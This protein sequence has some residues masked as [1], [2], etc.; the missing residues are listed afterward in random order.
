MRVLKF[1]GSS[2]ADGDAIRSVAS[3]VAAQSGA[4][5]VV[6]SALAGVT[7]ALV[8]LANA[9][10]SGAD[11]R[12]DLDA[13]E[14]RH[15]AIART[16]SDPQRRRIA[17][18]S[19]TGFAES[20]GRT[21]RAIKAEARI[22]PWLLDKL[23]AV[24]ELWSSR[25]VDGLLQEAGVDSHWTDA[26]GV[27]KTD[28]RHQAASPDLDATVQCLDRLVR[29]WLARQRVVV[30][31][32]FIGSGPDG[33]V[34]TL[35]RGGSDYSATILGAC[36]AAEEI[37][38]W[39]DVDGVHS[40]DPRLVDT[41]VVLP[42]LSF[43]SA[44]TLARF[45]AKILHP[46]AIAPAAARGIPVHVLNSFRPEAPGTRIGPTPAVGS[47]AVSAVSAHAGIALV[48]IRL[49][50]GPSEAGVVATVFSALQD[51]GVA[52][53]LA[54]LCDGRLAVAIEAAADLEPLRRRL[55]SRA[56]VHVSVGHAAVCVIAEP[57]GRQ[58][59]LASDALSLLGNT[60]IHLIAQPAGGVT[61]G[62][63]VDAADAVATV[64]RLHDG[65]VSQPQ[66]ALRRIVA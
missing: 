23:L 20:A 13:L 10:A 43:E 44:Q 18:L 50:N 41:A 53:L 29:P 9:A 14:L 17:E 56:G 33:A 66:S 5:V 46:R 58:G 2:V 15:A 4:T 24:G 57:V 36:L 22:R 31:G 6:V 7:D 30:L 16:I 63:V 39:T 19:T 47:G 62:L 48:E 64:Q 37:Q 45:G 8:G 34:T 51:G 54:E 28:G 61:L 59:R 42:V 35:G 60:A 3:I 49:D 40:A 12:R 11:C 25:L 27:L 26:R 55:G 1:G 21:L 65:F 52:V 32:G 38:I